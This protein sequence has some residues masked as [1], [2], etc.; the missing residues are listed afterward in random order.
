VGSNPTLAA[1][2]EQGD[3]PREPARVVSETF[4]GEATPRHYIDFMTEGGPVHLTLTARPPVRALAIA[5]LTALVGAGLMVASRVFDLGPVVLVVGLV[6]VG[7]AV[8]LAVAALILVAWARVDLVMDP[9]AITVRRAAQERRVP[10]A[11]IDSVTLTGP[12]L[13]LVRKTGAGVVVVNPRTPTDPTFT[14]LLSAIQ[15]R[16]DADRGYRSR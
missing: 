4:A 7:L 15:H 14:A 11:D 1:A 5:A 2:V 9:D 6:G 16:L 13:I 3:D 8:A 12:R 10:W